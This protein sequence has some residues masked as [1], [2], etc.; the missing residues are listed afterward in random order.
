[1]ELNRLMVVDMVVD[2]MEVAVD[3]VDLMHLVVVE[4]VKV[5]L[6]LVPKV[7][8]MDRLVLMVEVAAVVSVAMHQMDTLVV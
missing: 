8:V 6:V 7:M 5:V 3:L 1:M 2:P 4:M